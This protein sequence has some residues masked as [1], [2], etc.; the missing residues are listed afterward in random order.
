PPAALVAIEQLLARLSARDAVQRFG[1]LH[2]VVDAA[3]QA[4]AS[5]RDVDVR[6]VAREEHPSLAER[7][8]DALMHPV[9]VPV[10]EE[11]H[12]MLLAEL[13]QP[14]SHRALGEGLVVSLVLPGGKHRPPAPVE[15]VA[16]DLE[17]IGPFLGV[18]K[19]AARA[20]TESSLEIEPR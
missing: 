16:H 11:L 12:R 1:E 20:A 14:P 7:L 8:R 9:D 5:D 19:V 4:E 2:R 18:G 13:S 6:R 15:A 17:E 10:R 3:V